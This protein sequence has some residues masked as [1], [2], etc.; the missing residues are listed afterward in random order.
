ML[1]AITAHLAKL[2]RGIFIESLDPWSDKIRWLGG[3]EEVK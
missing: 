1:T 2:L 3:N